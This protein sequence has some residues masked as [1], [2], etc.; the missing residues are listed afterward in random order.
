MVH[1]LLVEPLLERA[2]ILHP[3][4][5]GGQQVLENP[6]RREEIA[7]ADLTQIGHHRAFAFRARDGEA[8]DIGLTYREDEIADPGHWQVGQNAIILGQLIE[9]GGRAPCVDNVLVRQDN[10]LGLARRA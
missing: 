9:L 8:G 2:R 4:G 10:T 1:V 3:D 6:W 7:G 5:D